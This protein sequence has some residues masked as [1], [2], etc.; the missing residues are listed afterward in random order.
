MRNDRL[1]S[2]ALAALLSACGGGLLKDSDTA[3]DSMDLADRTAALAAVF[4][5]GIDSSANT[6]TLM[7]TASE[8][9]TKGAIMPA[10]CLTVD[11][12][13]NGTVGY[14]FADCT[15]PY[16]LVGLKNRVAAA[17]S[18]SSGDIQIGLNSVDTA[19]GQITIRFEADLTVTPTSGVRTIKATSNSSVTTSRGRTLTQGGDYTATYDGQCLTLAGTFGTRDENI[20]W[21]TTVSN[22]RHC[23]GSCPKGTVAIAKPDSSLTVTYDG[24]STAHAENNAGG[25]GS[26]SLTCGQ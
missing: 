11:H 15:G 13:V 1:A 26:I 4:T 23:A 16:G 2:C 19:A 20:T 3:S 6:A 8:T 7:A 21:N 14:T 5:A 25:T 22:Y 18:L 24:S 17:F 10:S 12:P 9:G